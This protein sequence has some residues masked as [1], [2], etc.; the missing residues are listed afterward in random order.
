MMPVYQKV[1]PEGL[2]EIQD[3]LRNN[4]LEEFTEP[5]GRIKTKQ[6]VKILVL[7]SNS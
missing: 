2:S 5:I 1:R 4:D 3:F 6:E 7:N